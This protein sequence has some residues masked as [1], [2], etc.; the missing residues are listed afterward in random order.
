MAAK[1]DPYAGLDKQVV[2]LPFTEGLAND[3]ISQFRPSP[4]EALL[5]IEN[6]DLTKVGKFS[7]RDGFV[8]LSNATIDSVN[9]VSSIAGTQEKLFQREN[10]LGVIA[11]DQK[12]LGSGAGWGGV[13]D[14]VYTYTPNVLPSSGA[15]KAHGKI[16]RPT[17]SNAGNV[18]PDTNTR[19]C[20]C[21]VTGN[22]ML[23]AWHT[24]TATNNGN[25][26]QGDILWR[27]IDTTNNA[28]IVDTTLFPQSGTLI[29]GSTYSP[30]GLGTQFQAKMQ[31]LTVGSRLYCFV[32]AS[33]IAASRSDLI[34][35]SIDMSAA[36][37]TPTAAFVLA[38]GAS[39]Y[40]VSTDGTNIFIDKV[41]AATPT[42]A[43]CH[44]Y[45]ATLGFISGVTAFT[46]AGNII[47]DVQGSTAFGAHAAVY[48]TVV[49][50][51]G[52]ASLYSVFLNSGSLAVTGSALQFAIQ[53][54]PA[55]LINA[56][57]NAS[58]YRPDIV[59]LSSTKAAFVFTDDAL[60]AGSSFSPGASMRWGTLTVSAGAVTN[61]TCPLYASGPVTFNFTAASVVNV[62]RM[63]AINGRVFVPVVKCDILPASG[64]NTDYGYFLLELNIAASQGANDAFRL[65]M[66]SAGWAQDRSAPVLDTANMTGFYTPADYV[67]PMVTASAVAI[68]I[69]ATTGYTGISRPVRINVTCTLGGARGVWTGSVFYNNDPVAAQTFVSDATHPVNLIG[70]GL[71]FDLNIVAGVAVLADAWNSY[72]TDTVQIELPSG[73]VSGNKYYCAMR[74]G[75]ALGITPTPLFS[76]YAIDAI[77]LDFV[78]AYRWASRASG[79]LVAFAC[80]VPW[81]FDGRR[82]FEC[83]ILTRPRILEIQDQGTATGVRPLTPGFT[84]FFRAVYTWLDAR[85][86]RW[87]SAPSYAGRS[88]DDFS[89]R[90]N[91]GV[92][93]TVPRSAGPQLDTVTAYSMT[94]ITLTSALAEVKTGLRI[95]STNNGIVGGPG[96]ALFDIYYNGNAAAAM[97]AVSP[98]V[99]VAVPLTG[100]ATGLSLT[101][102]AG[103][104]SAGQEW[105]TAPSQIRLSVTLPQCFSGMV[106]GVDFFKDAMEVW[107][108]MTT[109]NTPNVYLLAAQIRADANAFTAPSYGYDVFSKANYIPIVIGNEPALTNDQIYTAGGELE[110]S[111]PPPARIIEAYRDRL[112]AISGYDNR[113]YYTK[114]R[115][116]GRGIE[117][118]QQTQYIDIPETGQGL[119]S[120][121]TCLM[122]FTTRGVY[123]I[124]GYGPSATGQP[125]QAFG[126]LQLI[127]NQLGLYEVN[128]CK[129]TPVGVIFRTSQGWWLVDRTL[130]LS[131]IG[132]DIDAMITPADKTIAV[133]VDQQLACV[134]IMTLQGGFGASSYLAYNYWYDSKRWSTDRGSLSTTYKDAMVL[135]ETYFTIDGVNVNARQG[136]IYGT[137][138][139]DGG[140][141]QNTDVLGHSQKVGTGWITV[142]NMA[143]LKRIWRVICT[144]ENL[145]DGTDTGAGTGGNPHT[146]P[147]VRLRVWSDW[148]DTA[149]T[150]DQTWWANQIGLGVQT[151]RAHLPKQKMKAIRIQIEQVPAGMDGGG[152]GSYN[153]NPGYN[154]IGFGFEV[155]LKNRL[156]TESAGQSR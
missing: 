11:N 82:L 154:F 93:G 30:V 99:A 123:A 115:I 156:S 13:G 27:V 5:V 74:S 95:V 35:F 33:N 96:N 12:A 131:Y 151:I 28:T 66:V 89:H 68:F 126:T 76:E 52:I 20:D 80:A 94:T 31:C 134:R 110:N 59:L 116:A 100:E 155:G 92:V 130:S 39:T 118:A 97:T 133:S 70:K 56:V 105:Q 88:G 86:D 119:A 67:T 64:R 24:I 121:E 111:A 143:M 106:S 10:E 125:A 150:F 4:K 8:A 83:G 9:G 122:I 79:Q 108:Y 153:N 36:N 77:S 78:D 26:A 37:P 17:L 124:E 45:S 21:A 128:S 47:V 15:W 23:I 3:F 29:A 75:K 55:Y 127:S 135:N 40:C 140:P 104:G 34:G 38:S 18:T 41:F 112:F 147:G 85:G 6:M 132:N 54:G 69:S 101:W 48:K 61:T 117:W 1:F 84:Y 14:T 72:Q 53:S 65:P 42:Q 7:N 103:V 73:A 152:L 144:L 25:N 113:V 16:P 60:T 51:T 109:P 49:T 63:F 91:G 44:A 107:V 148:N 71:G 139:L 81:A 32:L 137:S 102:S 46:L 19:I 43:V 62:S 138:W 2:E 98:A 90:T 58:I 120:N 57:S 145:T 114:S 136:A 129:T 149:P 141:T 50:A 146:N 142:A 87:F 22:F